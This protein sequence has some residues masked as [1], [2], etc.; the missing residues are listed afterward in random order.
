[1]LPEL[2]PYTALF[3]CRGSASWLF[4]ASPR[5]PVRALLWISLLSSASGVCPS[6]NLSL[7]LSGR[8]TSGAC[9]FVLSPSLPGGMNLLKKEMLRVTLLS[10][11][12]AVTMVPFMLTIV[13][14][15]GSKGKRN[16]LPGYWSFMTTWS[17]SCSRLVWARWLWLICVF[18]LSRLDS[19]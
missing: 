3:R 10:P 18:R 1:M 12:F 5:V 9:L 15:F 2:C 17:H 6:A 4:P 8:L 13:H 19:V 7:P 11:L 14:A 16:L